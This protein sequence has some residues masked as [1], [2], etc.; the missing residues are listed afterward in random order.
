MTDAPGRAWRRAMK[1]LREDPTIARV[2]ERTMDRVRNE[3]NMEKLVAAG[4]Q[5]GNNPH[6]AH[7]IYFDRLHPWLITIGDDA[8]L[9][10]FVAVITHDSSLAHHTG[11]T[12]L[13]RVVVG[14][15]VYV[16]VGAIL[17]PGTTIGDDSVVG[18]GAVVH[19]EIPP[20][21]LVTGNPSEAAPIKPV[22]AWQRASA[23]RSP[24]WPRE[25]WSITTGIT[26]E[27]KRV[28]LEALSNGAS[29]YTPARAAPGSPF[30]TRKRRD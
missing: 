9:S 12:R 24:T 14:N 13:G 10:P 26:E 19:G 7:P 30:A 2:R 20:G 11:Q 17:L 8:T 18:A 15:R 23:A 3:P 28:Q 4:L 5:L 27:R 1:R 21:S 22:A 25:G 29:G 16:G 6:I